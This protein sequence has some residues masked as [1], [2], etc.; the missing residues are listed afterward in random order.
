[1]AWIKRNLFFLIG[2]LVA[3][4]LMAGGGFFLYQQITAEGAVA[5]Q[6]AQQYTELKRLYSQNPH[7]GV[8]PIDNIKTAHDEEIQLRDYTQKIRTDFQHIPAIPDTNRVS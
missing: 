2:S 5:G 1:M 6:I 4:A 7:P 8:P 3:L